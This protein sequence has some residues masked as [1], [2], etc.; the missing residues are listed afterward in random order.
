M[1]HLQLP[2]LIS[3]IF[4]ALLVSPESSYA[5][6]S[7][8]Y[9]GVDVMKYTKD[10]MQGQPSDLAIQNIVSTIV[11]TINPTHISIATPLDHTSAYP[12]PP[13]PRTAEAF[14]KKW[15][16]TIH[17][18]GKKVIFR[19]TWSGIEGIYNFPKL[20]GANRFP[21]GTK[22]SAP[23][24]G[25]TTWLGKIYKYIIDNPE[26]FADGD[27]WAVLP[28]RTE[29]IFQD[30]TSFLPHSGAGIQTNYTN[31][32]NDLK[33]VSDAAFSK[34]GKNVVTGLT[35]NN[36]TEVASTWLPQ[37]I[38][39]TAG[40]TVVD[41]YGSN[42]TPEEMESDLRKI[43]ALRG[44]K[45]FLQE[46]GDY[47]NTSL[48]STQRAA[49]LTS[50]FQVWQKLAN[51]GILVG[52]NYWGAWPN[53]LEGILTDLGNNTFMVN[54]RGLMLAQ[55]YAG[56]NTGTISPTPTP[57]PTPTPTPSPTPTPPPPPPAPEPDSTVTPTP[58]PP[59]PPSPTPTP[60]PTPPPTKNKKV[61]KDGTLV[62]GNQTIYAIE[63]EDARP[64]ASMSVFEGYGY[65]MS[66]VVSDDISDL[67]IGQGL[68]DASQRHVR[69]SLVDD[70]GTI[71]F[72]GTEIRYAFA[73][74]QIFTS[75]GSEFKDIVPANAADLK[76]PI[77]PTVQLNMDS[78]VLGVSRDQV[79]IGNLIKGS[80]ETVYEVVEAEVLVPFYSK[81]LFWS[82]GYNFTEVKVLSD[83]LISTFRITNR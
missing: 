50:M 82:K 71:Y 65:K 3:A 67:D 10:T 24:D 11:G 4:L 68:F 9:K 38:F 80:S 27:I 2:I 74:E 17:A 23:T 36:Y 18:N 25:N 83:D 78:K 75:W 12:T 20:V 79:Q 63:H 30:S 46:W 34:I 81:E 51:E 19:G 13:S 61:Y 43:Y 21:A 62:K 31:F 5:Q 52:Y 64:I 48:T 41:H 73:S 77:G 39:D 60:S 76:M 15:T 66:N 56:N 70:N 32:F 26:L 69:G 37:S 47:W 28:E 58:P 55:F 59:P 1:K 6:T 44:K 49:Y 45:V 29:G 33:Y 57:A 53:N 54:D 35:A 8:I 22:I 16:D 40:M 42:H 7:L 14:T 72:L